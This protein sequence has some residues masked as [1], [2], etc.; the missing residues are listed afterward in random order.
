MTSQL[1]ILC[2]GNGAGKSTFYR[3]FLLPKGLEIVSVDEAARQF[4]PLNP[5][6]AI[7]EAQHWVDKKRYRMLER[8]NSFCYETVFSHPSKID[9]VADAKAG[10]YEVIL[11]YIHLESPELN[12]ARVN[13]RVSQGGQSHY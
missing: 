1:W 2:G 12:E 8:K 10:G 7:S 13:Q 3:T 5:S 4:E 6:D 9:F 11:V